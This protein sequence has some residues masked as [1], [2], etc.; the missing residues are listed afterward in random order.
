MP[1][2][3][4]SI[5]A[6]RAALIGDRAVDPVRA[7]A[8][9]DLRDDVIEEERRR[10]L[11]AEAMLEARVHERGIGLEPEL[12]QQ[13]DEQQRLVLAVAPARRRASPT[14]DAARASCGPSRCRGSGCRPARSGWRR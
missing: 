11:L 7:A 1:S 9:D 4:V 13:R 8:V 6:Q 12:A 3:G 14:A 10:E 2:F 5:V